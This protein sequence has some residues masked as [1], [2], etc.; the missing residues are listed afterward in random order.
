[1][2]RLLLMLLFFGHS[3]AMA[4]DNLRHFV[5]EGVHPLCGINPSFDDKPHNIPLPPFAR[6]RTLATGYSIK[7]SYPEP[8]VDALSKLILAISNAGGWEQRFGPLNRPQLS[9]RPARPLGMGTPGAPLQVCTVGFLQAYIADYENQAIV[10]Q[11]RRVEQ[12]IRRL[13]LSDQATIAKVKQAVA[14][15]R[16]TGPEITFEDVAQLLE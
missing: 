4:E 13:N 10:A 6:C 1:M 7:E 12:S 8:G 11:F 15:V 2:K 14:V 9:C 16:A 5:D 3:F